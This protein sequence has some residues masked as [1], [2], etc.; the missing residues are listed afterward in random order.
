[1]ETSKRPK[2]VVVNA[3]RLNFDNRLDFSS[4]SAI[5][6][7]TLYEDSTPTPGKILERVA[8]QDIV[9]TKEIMIPSDVLASFPKSV[10]LVC[11]AGTGFNNHHCA[12][13]R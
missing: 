13:A 1:M 3:G 9:I 7:L 10:K 12:R 6:E 2:A 8:G 5:A 11:E 4:L